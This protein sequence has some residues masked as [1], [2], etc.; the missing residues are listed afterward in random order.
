MGWKIR[1]DR[2]TPELSARAQAVFDEL[3]MTDEDVAR[4]L[5]APETVQKHFENL[6]VDE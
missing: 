6:A 2:L 1:P 5:G 4:A 3:G